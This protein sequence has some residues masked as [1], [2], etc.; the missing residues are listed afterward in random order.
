MSRDGRVVLTPAGSDD[1]RFAIAY[2]RDHSGF[3]VSNDKFRDHT[4][5]GTASV[6]TGATLGADLGVWLSTHRISYAF[7]QAPPTPFSAAQAP[8]SSP[9]QFVA[10][11]DALAR[12]SI[13]IPVV[14]PPS[15]PAVVAAAGESCASGSSSSSSSSSSAAVCRAR[16]A[17]SSA[18]YQAGLVPHGVAG[19]TPHGMAVAAHNGM[20]GAAASSLKAAAPPGETALA[21]AALPARPADD[22][23]L[24]AC[25]RIGAA[26]AAAL[27]PKLPTDIDEAF[28]AS[29]RGTVERDAGVAR[30]AAAAA[31]VEA[32]D[33]IAAE[34]VAVLSR[35]VAELCAPRGPA[36]GAPATYAVPPPAQLEAVATEASC[37]VLEQRPSFVASLVNL[38][39]RGD[40]RRKGATGLLWHESV[41]RKARI[42]RRARAGL[43]QLLADSQP[44][45]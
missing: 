25:A 22:G 5:R 31:L 15:V 10:D 39:A 3:I 1:D 12:A 7:V 37:D 24:A 38:A 33:A 14:P 18:V 43:L 8:H 27:L 44:T 40:L 4:A 41:G 21:A 20:A 34:A 32:A 2:A 42:E 6:V 30:R 28:L 16:A 23:T 11:P 35:L 45:A 9:L 19:A 36:G 13:P 17:A 26:V 29:A